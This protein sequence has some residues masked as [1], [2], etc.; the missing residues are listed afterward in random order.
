MRTGSA[1]ADD[2][3]FSTTPFVKAESR[4]VG[5]ELMPL[6]TAKKINV[7][8]IVLEKQGS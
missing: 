6:I 3:A 2:P 5:V 8:E 1:I 4:K 7:T